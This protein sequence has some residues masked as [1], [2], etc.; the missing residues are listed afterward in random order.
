MADLAQHCRITRMIGAAMIVS[1]LAYALVVQLIRINFAPF[2]GFSRFPQ[3]EV[4]RYALVG[5]A[6]ADAI[7]IRILKARL[8]AARPAAA[9]PGVRLQTASIVT[10]ALCEAVGLFGFVL[11]LIAGSALDFYFFLVLS[12]LLFGIHFPRW[13]QW[14]EWARQ[15]AR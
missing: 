4:L 8:L 14:E 9:P 12:L 2:E 3:W 10:F 1:L 15:V 13:D 6:V 7:L 11:F 5:L